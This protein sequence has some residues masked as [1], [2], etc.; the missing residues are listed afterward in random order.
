MKFKP[1]A[2][3][4]L[5]LIPAALAPAGAADLPAKAPVTA[6]YAPSWTG[7]Y[8]GVNGGYISDTAKFANN[9]LGTYCWI[10]CSFNDKQSATGGLLG[11]QIGYNFQFKNN[12]VI[13]WETDFAWSSAKKT[14][15]GSTGSYDWTNETGLSSFGTSRLRLGY[16]F[17]RLFM[18]GTGGLAFGNVRNR[19]QADNSYT[20]SDRAGFKAGWTAGGGLEY[21]LNPNWSIKAEGLFYDLGKSNHFSIDGDGYTYG[22]S[23]RTTG[24]VGRVGVNYMFR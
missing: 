17:D 10:S 16:A 24:A 5:G 6:K 19:H 8:L 3:S 15:S 7:F 23:D 1:L 11:G 12:I 20:W 14:T 4:S 13:G 2:L 9:D 21:A 18:Y 22:L